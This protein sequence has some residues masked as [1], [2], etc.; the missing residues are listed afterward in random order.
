MHAHPNAS[1]F[2]ETTTRAREMLKIATIAL[3]LCFASVGL[4]AMGYFVVRKSVSISNVEHPFDYIFNILTTTLGA[5]CILL[6]ALTFAVLF[7]ACALTVVDAF[8]CAL[9]RIRATTQSVDIPQTSG[10]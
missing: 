6:S 10:V 3:A 4:S 8:R 2:S 9:S 7:V 5:V 1:E